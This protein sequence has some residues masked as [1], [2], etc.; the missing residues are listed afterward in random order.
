MSS[1]RSDLTRREQTPLPPNT[2]LPGSTADATPSSLFALPAVPHLSRLTRI[3]VP[4]ALV[5][6]AGVAAAFAAAASPTAPIQIVDAPKIDLS[7][8]DGGLAPIPGMENIQVFRASRIRPELAEGKGYTY[9]HHPDLAV[10]HGRFYVAWDSGAKDEDTWPARELFSTSTDGRRWTSPAELFPEG[11]STPMRL[12]FFH[13]PNGRMLAF[14]GLRVGHEK[15]DEDTKGPLVVREIRADHSLGPVFTLRPPAGGARSGDP[16]PYT[17]ANDA[18]FT[19]ACRQLLSARVTLETQDL[20]VLLDPDQRMKW[21]RADAWPHDKIGN[22]F[23]KAPSFYHR[24]DGAIVGIGKNGWTSVTHDNGANWSQPVVPPSLI[25]NN[26][27][28]WGQRTPDGHYLLVY[29][30]TLRPRYPLALVV[31]DDGMVF[32]DMRAVQT[33]FTSQR[34]AGINKNPGLQYIRGIAEWASDDSIEDTRHAVWLVYS[35]NKEDIWVSRVP[36]PITA[37]AA[38]DAWSLYAPKWS[39]VAATDATATLESREPYDCAEAVRFFT[40]TAEAAVSFSITTPPVGCGATDIQLITTGGGARPV[41]LRFAGDGFLRAMDRDKMVEEGRFA[42]GTQVTLRIEAKCAPRGVYS[43]FVDNRK[44][45]EAQFAEP[46]AMLD[47]VAFKT[48]AC[49]DGDRPTTFLPTTTNVGPA[50]DQ[51][52]TA[53]TCRVSDLKIETR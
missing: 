52:A 24:A 17:D 10:W 47:Q 13:A 25:T 31:G 41:R 27:K 33:R 9:N 21:H 19:E 28:V 16:A 14:S 46:A 22:G 8:T 34:Y 4:A 11:V 3:L 5:T 45:D 42:P 38:T 18:P 44:V 6:I 29:N 32:R 12:Y 40:P 30:P 20:G 49:T 15:T 39:S 36:L 37:T 35:A 26:A 53:V 48:W 50:F 43:V 23:W 7:R 1:T 51:P 2:P